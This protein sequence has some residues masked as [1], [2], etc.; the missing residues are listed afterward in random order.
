[1][2]GNI[3]P[4]IR[5]FGL[6]LLLAGVQAA[7]IPSRA[8]EPIRFVFKEGTQTSPNAPGGIVRCVHQKALPRTTGLT[9][10]YVSFGPLPANPAKLVGGE[11]Q[12]SQTVTIGCKDGAS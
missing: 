2:C 10:V 6:L 1:M 5:L 11:A 9:Y 7:S 4:R 8:D 12:G 3:P